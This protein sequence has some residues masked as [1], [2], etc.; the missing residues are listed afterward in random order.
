M[1]PLDDAGLVAA[2]AAAEDAA[3]GGRD[4]AAVRTKVTHLLDQLAPTPVST[5]TVLDHD[6][7]LLALHA[8][9][10]PGRGLDGA[11]TCPACGQRLDVEIDLPPPI[12]DDDGTVPS[13]TLTIDDH[14]ME[15]RVPTIGDLDAALADAMTDP[16]A[17]LVE[18]VVVAVRRRDGGPVDRRALL[19]RDDVRGA[20]DGTVA[21]L[22]GDGLVEEVALDCPDC[23]ETWQAWPDLEPFALRAVDDAARALLDD[24]HVL[25]SAYGWTPDA[26]LLMPPAVRRHHLARVS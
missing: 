12:P 22:L 16:V 14:E 21:E 8:R 2:W 6:A 17:D 3:A 24:V 19:A 7:H 18:R 15:V 25:A 5:R 9:A 13:T 4:R 23:G 1:R 20:V 26:V 11:A 10:V